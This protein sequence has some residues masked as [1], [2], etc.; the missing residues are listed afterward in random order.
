MDALQLRCRLENRAARAGKAV[1][2]LYLR[3]PETAWSALAEFAAVS[4]PAHEEA[5]LTLALPRHALQSWQVPAQE[6]R[7]ACGPWQL[8]VGFASDD[9][10][11]TFDFVLTPDGKISHR[12]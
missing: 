1:V 11:A 5:A 9:I 7:L 6:W 3:G 8:A 2:Q 12:G 4:V 10:R